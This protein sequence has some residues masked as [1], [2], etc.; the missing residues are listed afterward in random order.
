MWGFVFN[1]SERLFRAKQI[2]KR[3]IATMGDLGAVPVIIAAFP[4]CIPFYPECIWW[5]PFFNESTVLLDTS[6]E[7]GTPEAACFSRAALAAFY[8]RA[9][10]PKPDKIFATTG[11]TCDDYS[12]T[13]QSIEHLGHD[14]TW[15]EAPFRRLMK[16]SNDPGEYVDAVHGYTYPKRFEG[17]LIKEYRRIWNIMADLTGT[18]AEHL[19][20]KSIHKANTLRTLVRNITSLA[21]D[22]AVMPFPALELMTIE[23]GN[24]YWYADI[25]EWTAILTMIYETIGKRVAHNV[26]VQSPDA[27]PIAWINPT[28]DPYLLNFVEDLGLRVCATE[29][30]IRQALVEID[31]TLDPFRALARSFMQASLIGSTRE[32]IQSIKE[33]IDQG[34]IKGVLITNMLGGSHCAMETR[35]MEKMIDVVPVLSLDIPPPPGVTEQIKNRVEAF[36]ESLR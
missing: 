1:E 12:C 11:A 15:I 4:D 22:A 5:M 20:G 29:Y 36:A 6:S 8:K 17:Y 9:Y 19:L 35:I 27:V 23:F 34:K 30:V 33:S 14:I 13:M 32:R 3:I 18:N 28:A 7:L 10:F 31:E 25:E 21:Y 26:G 2:G 24:L 16:D